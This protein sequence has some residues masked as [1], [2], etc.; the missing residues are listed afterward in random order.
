MKKLLLGA[1]LLLSMLGF[2]QTYSGSVYVIP[3]TS[4]GQLKYFSTYQNPTNSWLPQLVPLQFTYEFMYVCPNAGNQVYTNSFRLQDND[5]LDILSKL[6]VGDGYGSNYSNISTDPNNP[7]PINIGP[8]SDLLFT[9]HLSDNSWTPYSFNAYTT[10]VFSMNSLSTNQNTLTQLNL[11]PNPTT[12]DLYLSTNTDK[13]IKIYDMIGNKVIDKDITNFL[14]TS[15][16]ST[17]VYL[18]E[19]IEGENKLTKKIVK[20]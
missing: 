13:N 10:I 18:C 2:S 15:N 16:L 5:W 1:L 7:T 8:N 14:D 9:L 12:G 4:N 3:N 11:Y 17:G 19:I 6:G 20:N